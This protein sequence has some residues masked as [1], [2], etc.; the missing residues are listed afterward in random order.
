MSFRLGVV[1]SWNDAWFPD[2][3][4]TDENLLLRETYARAAQHLPPLSRINPA[5]TPNPENLFSYPIGATFP[6][7]FSP[8]ITE[9]F[10]VQTNAANPRLRRAVLVDS[11]PSDVP[12]TLQ[13]R[14]DYYQD[15]AL[16]PAMVGPIPDAPT[17]TLEQNLER[18]SDLYQKFLS[19]VAEMRQGHE[20]PPVEPE[21]ISFWRE[22]RDWIASHGTPQEKRYK[23]VCS[24]CL[25]DKLI[26]KNVQPHYHLTDQEQTIVL[27]CGH[28]FGSRCFQSILDSSRNHISEEDKPRATCPLC[29]TS[30]YYSECGHVI[31]G[32]LAPA[33]DN[34]SLGIIPPSVADVG[35][36]AFP[37]ACREC[38][39][40][41]NAALN[42]QLLSAGT[43]ALDAGPVIWA[44]IRERYHKDLEGP[45]WA[46]PPDFSF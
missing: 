7:T 25:T 4:G 43:D 27:P 32:L 30:L 12:L 6:I 19:D 35:P 13:Q 40:A 42:L 9:T 8:D 16:Q 39:L 11:L 37:R 33:L 46:N 20:V 24:I 38:A 41:T 17:L 44:N 15:F 10:L 1:P 36:S 22:A 5:A 31:L 2:T 28:M 23:A 3:P 18:A 45:N 21:N 29:R 14:S 26:L 34:H